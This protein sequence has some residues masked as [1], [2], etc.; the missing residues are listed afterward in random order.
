MAL[1]PDPVSGRSRVRSITVHGDQEM[2]QAAQVRWAA[3]AGVIRLRRHA[4]PGMTVAELL[5]QWLA[6]DHGWR[7]STLV[8]YRSAAKHVAYDVLGSRRVVQLSPAVMR[9]ACQQW[10]DEGWKDPTIWARV[11]MLRSAVGWAYCERIVEVDPLDGMRNPPHA[12][13]RLHASVDQVREILHHAR[14]DS[15]VAGSE[16]DGTA[17][18]AARL[19]R[20][21]QVLLLAHLA[22]NSGARR[23]ELAS[24]QLGDLDGDILTISRS[25]SN[26]ILGRTKSGRI[27]RMTLGH[28][29]AEL[30]RQ[31]VQR[32]QQRSDGKPFGPWLFS[33]EPGHQ[34]R[35]TTSCLGHWFGALAHEANHPDVT[36]HRLRHSAATNLVSRGDILHAQ[37]RLGHADAATTL[38][39]YSHAMPLTDAD[40]AAVLEKLYL[41]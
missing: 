19:H 15:E 28:E 32:W 34:V 25:T 21:E 8:G 2:A 7:P 16:F 35:L 18:A 33:A 13:V 10:R 40:A 24:L 12:A 11:R 41:W 30:W 3:E 39:V 38:R 14:V 29:T 27:R 1:G 6:A 20:A 31:T 26:E 36:L 22:A 23:G 4:W 5:T 17:P 37:C 9:T